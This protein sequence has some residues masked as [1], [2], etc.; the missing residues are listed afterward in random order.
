MGQ[1][2][3]QA[4]RTAATRPGARATTTTQRGCHHH[5]A[6]ATTTTQGSLANLDSQEPC[7]YLDFPTGR[8]KL[9]GTLV[10]PRNK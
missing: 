8:L 9:L 4:A 2:A 6:R 3:P 10:F 5:Y 7:M 1:R